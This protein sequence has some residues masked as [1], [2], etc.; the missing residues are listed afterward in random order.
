MSQTHSSDLLISSRPGRT[1]TALLEGGHLAELLVEDD[2]DR[3]LVGNIYLGRVEA[4]VP[5][6]NAAFVDIGLGKSGFLAMAEARPAGGNGHSGESISDY[7]SE[8]RALAVQVQRDP[9]ED[10]GAKLTSRLTINGR[11]LIF[12]PDDPAIRISR[13]IDDPDERQRLENLLEQVVEEGEGFILRT[14][15][16]LLDESAIKREAETLR[17]MWLSVEAGR[18]SG[19]PPA[20]LKEEDY[21]VIKSLRDLAD[22]NIGRIV[23]DDTEALSQARVYCE[24]MAP[25]LMDRIHHH[26]KAS[27]LFEAFDA[28]SDTV[29]DAIDE[30]LQDNVRLRSGGSVIFSQTPALTAIDVNTGGTGGGRYEEAAL[31]TNL[32]AAGTIGR[33][34]RLRNLSGL[35]AV[36]FVTMKRQD[37]ADKVLDALKKSVMG[38]STPVFVGGFTRFGLVE[39]TRRRRREPLA[40]AYLGPCDICE[41]TGVVLSPVALAYEALDK[42]HVEAEVRPMDKIAMTVSMEISDALK[43]RVAGALKRL[44]ERLGCEIHIDVDEAFGVEDYE[45]HVGEG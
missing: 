14:V 29:E 38:D 15:A 4:V 28:G 27:P 6:L 31:K 10:K 20:L 7:V 22:P 43:G 5:S 17:D 25:D 24:S 23:I 30:A 35:F 36:D 19:A 13:R 11:S 21:G 9:F 37:N 16:A 8:G 41:G 45:V 39:L 44:Q 18:D 12:T 2:A 42:L 3:S 32:E 40:S 1:R 34:I 26:A 33:Q